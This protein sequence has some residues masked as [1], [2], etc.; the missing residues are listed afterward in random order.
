MKTY[1][2]EHLFKVMNA[3]GE[4]PLW[5]PA[6]KKLYWTDILTGTLY[7]TNTDLT[8]YEKTFLDI[9][10]GAFAF[11][12]SGGMILASDHGFMEWTFEDHQIAYL[13]N[14]LIGRNAPRFNDGKVDPAGRFWAGSLDPQHQKAKL[15]RL[16][17]DGGHHTILNDIGISNGLDW[18]P[19]HK[20]MYYTDSYQYTIYE[21]DYDLKSGNITH[22][23]PF[24]VLPK[25]EREIVPDGLCVDA[26]GFIWSAQWNGWRIVRY[27]PQGEPVAIVKV[28]AQ[29]VT[30]CC[31]GGENLDLLLIT[32]SRADLSDD[33]LSNQPQAGDVFICKVPVQG[34]E[35][36]LFG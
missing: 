2:A 29:R 13:W 17:P 9:Q 26:E 24:I 8:S 10:V 3:L 22:Q 6:E 12:K 7:R 16:D 33:A 14:P 28:P 21:F 1:Y 35:T 36:N 20:W 5:H 30:S 31:F 15:Y 11:R 27:N 25:D 34:Q 18:R 19:D 32:T 23:K 4:G